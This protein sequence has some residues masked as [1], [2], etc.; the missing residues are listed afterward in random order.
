MSAQR[1]TNKL[2]VDAEARLT[3]VQFPGKVGLNINPIQSTCRLSPDFSITNY[4]ISK[5]SIPTFNGLNCTQIEE[6]IILSALEQTLLGINGS[7]FFF[8]VNKNSSPNTAYVYNSTRN[9]YGTP[10]AGVQFDSNNN[11]NDWGFVNVNTFS[12]LPRYSR[13]ICIGILNNIF[14]DYLSTNTINGVTY[15]LRAGID[16]DSHL[17]LTLT[18]P[19]QALTTDSL[20]YIGLFFGN[21]SNGSVNFGVTLPIPAIGRIGFEGAAFML[22][23]DAAQAGNPSQTITTPYVFLDFIPY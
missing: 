2:R 11:R 3:K 23:Y 17:T 21:I 6:G 4:T 20:R 5:C 10:V 8:V 15:S 7:N 13:E 19:I 9:R 22:E 12:G 14:S 18:P 1:Y 16:S